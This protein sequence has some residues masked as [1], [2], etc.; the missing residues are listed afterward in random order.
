MNPH[1]NTPTPEQ[2]AERAAEI[3]DGWS[4]AEERQRQ[5]GDG[6]TRTG[7]IEI[8]TPLND[9]GQPIG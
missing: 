5:N 4:L 1:S 6:R 7:I 3:R 8:A 2:I 9:Q